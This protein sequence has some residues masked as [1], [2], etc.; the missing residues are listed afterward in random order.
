MGSAELACPSL[1]A[2]VQRPDFHLV[3]VVTQPDRPRGRDLQL[4]PTPVKECATRVGL[5]VMQPERLRHE[6][7]LSQLTGL[8]P[9]LIV[10]VAY[11]QI[12]PPPVL[13]LPRFGCLNVHASLLPR[14][15]GAAPVQWAILNDEPETGVT[16]MR[17][18]AGLDTGDILTREATPITPTDDSR[19]VHDRLAALGARLLTETI[20]AWVAGTIIP[21]PQPAEGVTYARKIL[22]ADGHLDWRRPAR[23]LWNC[24]RAFAPWPGAF[25]FQPAP[26]KPV[27]LKIWRAEVAGALSGSSGEILRTDAQGIVVGCGQQALRLLELQREGGKRLRVPDFL[28][29]HAVKV[30]EKWA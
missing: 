5:P 30:G 23:A 27:L 13:T 18:D 11:G 2:L 3:G 22:K 28:A 4:Q 29:G 19:T 9:D 21:R 24:V 15:R 10:V 14:H 17:M 6:A 20:P 16:I 12:L 7:A 25:T 8:Q 26:L 1:E